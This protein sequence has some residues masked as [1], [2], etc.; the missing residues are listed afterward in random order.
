MQITQTKIM[1]LKSIATSKNAITIE[2]PWRGCWRVCIN[3]KPASDWSDEPS[4]IAHATRLGWRG[5][6]QV[7]GKPAS[8]VN[9]RSRSVCF[10]NEARNVML[11]LG[12]TMRL[13][14][15]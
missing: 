15:A 5:N 9:E 7:Q 1:S 10:V 8:L 2:T 13:A 11:S 12:P 14:F 4:A 3:N 6:D